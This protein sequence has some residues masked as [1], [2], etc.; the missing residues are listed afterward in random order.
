MSNATKTPKKTSAEPERTGKIQANTTKVVDPIR[1]EKG[2]FLPGVSGNPNGKPL[3]TKHMGTLLAE[4][5]KEL[6]SGSDTKSWAE[7]VVKRLIMNAVAGKEKS[8]EMIFD[9]MDGKVKDEFRGEISGMIAHGDVGDSQFEGLVDE[10]IAT[11]KK[12]N[13][14]RNEELGD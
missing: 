8:I 7:M 12:K 14:E 1:N 5:L 6:A 11:F 3:G 10:F 4:A 9:R 13:H 2:Q